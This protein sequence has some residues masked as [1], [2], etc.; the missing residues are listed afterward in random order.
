MD[1]QQFLSRR[2]GSFSG[3]FKSRHFNQN[4]SD[5]VR[6]LAHRSLKLFP[7]SLTAK[8]NDCP[9][10]LIS[11]ATCDIATLEELSAAVLPLSGHRLA[12][13]QSGLCIWRLDG[14]VGVTSF[15]S[16]APEL[17]EYLTT[18]QA[19]CGGAVYAL[20]WQPAGM[21]RIITPR[22]L[23]PGVTILGTETGF[24]VPPAG[25]AVWLNPGAEIEALPYVLRELLAS[26]PPDNPP[27]LVVPARKPS[28]RPV[29]CKSTER[30]PQPNRD[31]RKGHTNC[32]QARWNGGYRIYRQR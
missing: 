14:R 25:G 18:L 3:A 30:F 8:L 5:E 32:N 7:V 9:D 27:G 28:P 1:L 23:A 15:A 29:P 19:H 13:G 20:F 12:I 22:E 10:E 6:E 24:D 16:I 4:V 26:E 31:L 21:K 11:I 2:S 17:D